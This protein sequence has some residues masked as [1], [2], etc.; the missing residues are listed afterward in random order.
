MKKHVLIF[1][2]FAVVLSCKGKQDLPATDVEIWKLGWRLIAN[3]MEG[4][5]DLANSQF[6]SLRQIS[7]KIDYKYL[8]TGLE[9]KHWQRS[10]AGDFH[11]HSTCRQGQGMAAIST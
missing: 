1:T 7:S 8:V 4:K 11:D 2:I 6:D 9:V 3:A 10:Y 5:D